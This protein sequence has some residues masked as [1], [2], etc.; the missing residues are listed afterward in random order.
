MGQSAIDRLTES[1]TLLC[2]TAGKSNLPAA[3]RFTLCLPLLQ[4]QVLYAVALTHIDPFAIRWRKGQR[5]T[6]RMQ[7]PCSQVCCNTHDN[8]PASLANTLSRCSGLVIAAMKRSGR[9]TTIL[10]RAL[11]NQSSRRLST[12]STQVTP[13]ALK[14]SE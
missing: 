9:T 12:S 8:C 14:R 10:S 7:Q 4:Y 1:K 5:Y 6:R 11:A 3:Q 2:G 13:S